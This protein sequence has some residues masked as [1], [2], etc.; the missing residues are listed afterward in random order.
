MKNN[1]KVLLQINSVANWGSIG[2]DAEGIGK[3]AISRGWESYIAFGRW[4]NPSESHLIRIGTA[5]SMQ[6]DVKLRDVVI[7]MAA[8]TDSNI[9]NLRFNG[10]NYAPTA[11]PKLFLKAH[12]EGLKKGLNIKAGNIL[13]SDT[14]YGD[15]P[16]GWKK[17]AKFGI[18][19][20]EME[21]AQLYTLAAKYNVNALT[22]LTISDSL[23]TGET[24]TSEERQLTFN[25]MIEVALESALS[26]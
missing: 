20:V 9:N 19:C 10:A 1:K 25:N 3:A 12:E 26:L 21:A 8:S 17:W 5:G 4:S 15:D 7:G 23:V 6:E 16:D 13:T 18:L 14:F 24:T 11:S 22:I 2:K